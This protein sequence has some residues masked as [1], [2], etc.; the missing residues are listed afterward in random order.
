MD[1][2]QLFFFYKHENG[3]FDENN[4]VTRSRTQKAKT[5]AMWENN[6]QGVTKF[7]IPACLNFKMGIRSWY[8]SSCVTVGI[9]S[10]QK[11]Q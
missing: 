7:Q 2:Q 10:V 4:E 3:N 11:V 1:K 9:Y 5:K 8:T 6:R